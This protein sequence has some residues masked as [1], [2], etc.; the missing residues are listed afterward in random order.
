VDPKTAVLLG[1][2]WYVPNL[3]PHFL[4][5]SNDLNALK[6]KLWWQPINR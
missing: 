3:P 4:P 5:Q 1:K 6:E 2:L